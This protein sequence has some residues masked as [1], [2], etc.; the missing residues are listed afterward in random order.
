MLNLGLLRISQDCQWT[1]LYESVQWVMYSG[2]LGVDFQRGWVSSF[3]S[4]SNNTRKTT[5]SAS[6][7]ILSQ[8]KLKASQPHPCSEDFKNAC[9]DNFISRRRHGLVLNQARR[10]LYIIHF[11]WN[12][13]EACYKLCELKYGI[14]Y[15]K[16]IVGFSPY[17]TDTNV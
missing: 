17:L 3:S 11:L 7:Q 1:V 5:F 2:A 14:I 4:A 13:V 6:Y 15:S 8:P 16:C 9:N 12:V 10:L